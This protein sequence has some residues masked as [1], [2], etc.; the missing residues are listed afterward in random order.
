MLPP[1][2]KAEE[3]IMTQSHN[4]KPVVLHVEDSNAMAYLL[5]HALWQKKADVDVLRLCD[6]ADAMLYLT[7]VGVFVEAPL[8]AVIVLDLELPRKHGHEILAEIRQEAR[9]RHVPVIVFTSS[10]RAADRERS[11]ALGANHYFYKGD[12]KTFAAV[13]QQILLYVQPDAGPALPK[14]GGSETPT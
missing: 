13:S 10:V 6:G 8:P 1:L 14:C 3:G 2:S 4:V 9:F 7:R 12:L 11:L 5:R